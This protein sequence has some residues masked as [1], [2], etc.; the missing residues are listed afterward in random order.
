[1]LENA[2]KEKHLASVYSS[3]SFHSNAVVEKRVTGKKWGSKYTNGGSEQGK[4]VS[5]LLS[6][7]LSSVKY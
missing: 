4:Q 3:F 5:D 2:L 7:L 6:L 1:M